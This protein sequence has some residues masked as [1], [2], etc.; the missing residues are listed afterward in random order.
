MYFFRLNIKNIFLLKLTSLILSSIIPSGLIYGYELCEIKKDCFS[1]Y[2]IQLE[3]LEQLNR[4]LNLRLYN[5][6]VILIGDLNMI[7]NIYL[8]L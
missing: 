7:L 2:Q 4:F 6:K 8:C 5:Q 1:H 3:Q